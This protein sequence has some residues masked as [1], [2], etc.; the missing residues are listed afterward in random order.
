MR[1]RST[2]NGEPSPNGGPPGDL[3]I[4]IRIRKHDVFERDGDDLHCVVPI[5]MTRAAL[6]GDIEVPTLLQGKAVITLPEGT[7]HGKQ[8]RLRGKGIKG[9]RSSSAGDLYCHIQV[10][11]PVKLTEHQ[12]KLLKQ[13][14]E[15]LEKGGKKHSP[16]EKSWFDRAKDFFT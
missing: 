10:E 15:S 7:Q 8:F 16:S 11:T 4:E 5:S 9:V 1:I 13:L 6:G 2:G 14:D 3:Y 12:K